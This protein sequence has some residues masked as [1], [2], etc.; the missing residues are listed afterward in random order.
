MSQKNYN[1]SY[2]A[3]WVPQA[4]TLVTPAYVLIFFSIYLAIVFTG[5]D[6]DYQMITFTKN[7]GFRLV[8]MGQ[9]DSRKIQ[10]QV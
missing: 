6:S 9:F 3:W 1:Q 7:K 4:I 8:C 2:V 5:V 10:H